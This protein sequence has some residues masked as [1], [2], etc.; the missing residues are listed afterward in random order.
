M[1]GSIERRAL[2]YLVIWGARAE[3]M[4]PEQVL[5][6]QRDGCQLPRPD[7]VCLAP[8]SR[9]AFRMGFARTAV[10]ARQRVDSLIG[11]DSRFPPFLRRSTPI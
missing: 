2:A 5:R 4:V 9:R 6:S 10:S 3:R 1:A 11:F 7:R 8:F